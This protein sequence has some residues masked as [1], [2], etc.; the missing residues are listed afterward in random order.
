MWEWGRASENN[1]IQS[2]K[3]FEK[4]HVPDILESELSASEPE[5]VCESVG[6]LVEELVSEV[7]SGAPSATFSP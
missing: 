2:K 7:M 3:K 5:L 1:K 6:E 4:Y